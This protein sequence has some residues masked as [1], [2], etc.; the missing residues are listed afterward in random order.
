MA[1]YLTMSET[2][3][4]TLQLV[5]DAADGVDVAAI[6]VDLSWSFLKEGS[7]NDEDVM[8]T[9]SADAEDTGEGGEGHGNY[10]MPTRTD[11]DEDDEDADD[12]SEEDEE[13]DDEDE[14]DDDDVEFDE[15]EFIV[16]RLS[17]FFQESGE[18]VV[19]VAVC[20]LT[21]MFALARSYPC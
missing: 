6:Q 5:M 18:E 4:D 15:R 16:M 7:P 10:V 9:L 12:D 3:A 20:H 13:D 11:D 8:S 2:K 17:V 19:S 1:E 21:S 14:E